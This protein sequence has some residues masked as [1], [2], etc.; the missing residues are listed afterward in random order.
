MPRPS[1]LIKI[2]HLVAILCTLS[3][4]IWQQNTAQATSLPSLAPPPPKIYQ[5]PD[6]FLRFQVPAGWSVIQSNGSEKTVLAPVQTNGDAKILIERIEVPKGAHPRQLRLR[7]IEAIKTKLSGFQSQSERDIVISGLPAAVLTGTYPWQ[8][9]IQY[10]RA[11]E[12]VFVVHGTHAIRIHFECFQPLASQHAAAVAVLYK[13]LLIGP[14][15][16]STKGIKPTSGA[17]SSFVDSVSY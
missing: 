16:A 12:Q 15:K 3:G 10:P 9:N 4:V 2:R 1:K 6:A 5:S 8:G 13:S 11:L 7:A 14:K 17:G